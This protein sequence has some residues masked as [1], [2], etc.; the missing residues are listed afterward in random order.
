MQTGKI[1]LDAA[2]RHVRLIFTDKPDTARQEFKKE[3]DVNV[4]L[5]R[6]GVHAPQRP[7]Q[8]GQQIDYNID[9]QTAL[10]SIAAAKEAFRSLPDNL[11]N[12]Y[13]TWQAL[14]TALDRG[15]LVI[16]LAEPLDTETENSEVPPTP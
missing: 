6:F 2:A 8:M 9:L 12:K 5:Q 11:K 16:N 14:L 15:Q 3:A 7:G 13:Q 10:T 1:P 4:L